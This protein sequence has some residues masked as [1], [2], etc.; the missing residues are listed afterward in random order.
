MKVP[1][2]GVKIFECEV[3]LGTIVF[4]EQV[5]EHRVSAN[6]YS[7]RGV[8]GPDLRNDLHLAQRI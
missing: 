5:G 7:R 6:V 3:E 1:V 4:V 8:E 2:S